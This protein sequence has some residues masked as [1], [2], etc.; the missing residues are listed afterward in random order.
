MRI[1]VVL[2]GA[3]RTIKS[4]ERF[5]VRH[6]LRACPEATADVFACVQ[7]DTKMPHE[8]WT[9]WLQEVFSVSGACHV[10]WYTRV[11]ESTWFQIRNRLLERMD[12]SPSWK[13]YLAASGSMLEYYQLYLAYLRMCTVE[14]KQGWTY[15]FVIRV[16]TDSVFAKP[17]DFH[18][19]KWTPEEC[20]A[21][22][23]R[24]SDA[25]RKPEDHRD[26]LPAFMATLLSD[27]VIPNLP[28]IE[29]G[30][31]FSATVTKDTVA[32]YLQHGQYILTF[33][34]NNLYIVRRSLF[35]LI[36]S[37]LAFAYGTLGRYTTEP[38][39]WFNA[40]CQ[41]KAVCRAANLDVF[42]YH[43]NLEDASLACSSLWQASL[44]F[45]ERGEFKTPMMLFCLLRNHIPVGKCDPPA[46]PALYVAVKETPTVEAC[47][48]T[49]E[50]S[51]PAA[52]D[53]SPTTLLQATDS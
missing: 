51:A 4:A 33:R 15:D 36:P 12:I 9:A 43:T 31:E 21:R 44:F 50:S 24:V 16:R 20:A 52:C 37:A 47:T 29:R 1:A 18:W 5:H 34:R 19:L 30:G 41:F 2:T 38:D 11:M 46:A 39:Y 28:N 49:F 35:S 23:T 7:N 42:D 6:V 53:L 32:H 25:I 40:E 10:E 26:V 13:H 48:T 45:D 14:Q 22:W 27:D 8:D 3:L 17:V